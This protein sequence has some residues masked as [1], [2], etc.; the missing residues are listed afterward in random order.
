MM[1]RMPDSTGSMIMVT[2]MPPTSMMEMRMHMV[3]SDWT[4]DWTL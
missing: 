1:Q 3:C 2:E 4:Q